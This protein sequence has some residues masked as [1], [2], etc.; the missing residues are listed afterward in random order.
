MGNK[1]IFLKATTLRLR[2]EYRNTTESIREHEKISEC[3]IEAGK[4]SP[5]VRIKLLLSRVFIKLLT[6]RKAIL[7]RRMAIAD[8]VAKGYI[9]FMENETAL[10]Y[11]FNG[12]LFCLSLML[13]VY[14]LVIS[15]CSFLLNRVGSD[16]RLISIKRKMIRKY[17]I[18]KRLRTWK[19]N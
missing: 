1:R 12:L 18:T 19:K 6:R 4:F 8:Y 3:L 7:S 15:V 5:A 14:W 10:K 2:T 13:S 17:I 9:P 16:I 11:Y